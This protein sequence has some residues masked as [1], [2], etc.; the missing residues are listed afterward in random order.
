[1]QTN[2]FKEVEERKSPGRCLGAEPFALIMVVRLSAHIVASGI[3]S[4]SLVQRGEVVSYKLDYGAAIRLFYPH[5]VE[6]LEAADRHR[7]E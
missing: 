4:T 1:M 5:T 7:Y 6:P 2:S 3:I